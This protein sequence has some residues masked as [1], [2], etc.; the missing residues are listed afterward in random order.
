VEREVF[1]ETENHYITTKSKIRD[2]LKDE[3]QAYLILPYCHVKYRGAYMP[4]IK[5]SDFNNNQT[6]R[7]DFRNMFKALFQYEEAL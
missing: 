6:G 1:D 4:K 2:L 7:E 5:F 3:E